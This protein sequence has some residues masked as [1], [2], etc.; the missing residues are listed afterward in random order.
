MITAHYLTDLVSGLIDDI[1]ILLEA[2]EVLYE[3]LSN[4]QFLINV[5]DINLIK[6]VR[7]GLIYQGTSY[8]YVYDY[9]K[10]YEIEPNV[11]R[12]KS[13]DYCYQW[14]KTISGLVRSHK[15][16][17]GE[18]KFLVT[19]DVLGL[20]LFRVSKFVT[21]RFDAK[22]DSKIPFKYLNE[23]YALNKQFKYIKPVIAPNGEIA[24]VSRVINS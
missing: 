18:R 15:D 8:R 21:S 10:Y 12:L 5:D 2:E 22:K 7:K 24:K 6:E 16:H 17:E 3:I 14:S 23:F 9:E 20:D 19:S 11:L 1:S 4:G 13:S